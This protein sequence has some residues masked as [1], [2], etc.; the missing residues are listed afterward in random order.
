MK[1]KIEDINL[2]KI[3]QIDKE[4][5]E[6]NKIGEEFKK[7]MNINDELI[8]LDSDSES[9]YVEIEPEEETD[10]TEFSSN[11]EETNVIEF[12]PKEE[13]TVF[14]D[15]YS[16]STDKRAGKL[17]INKNF[18][19]RINKKVIAIVLVGTIVTGV[20]IFS[21]TKS[22]NKKTSSKSVSNNTITTVDQNSSNDEFGNSE[23]D[24][25]IE[26]NT[27]SSKIIAGKNNKLIYDLVKGID[28][29]YYI[30][31]YDINKT[32][33]VDVKNGYLAPDGKVYLSKSEYN[34][35]KNKSNNSKNNFPTST[36]SS[37][38]YYKASDGTL[39]ASKKDRDKYEKSL[40]EQDNYYKASDGTLFENK[41]DR[42]KYE[43][44]L[45]SQSQTK[46]EQTENSTTSKQ[47]YY[48]ADDGTL[49][50]NKEDR[51]KWNESLKKKKNGDITNTSVNSKQYQINE[52]KKIKRELINFNLTYN[53]N[54][55]NSIKSL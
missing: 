45:K 10:V 6:I 37:S 28:G 32:T 33:G 5:D 22:K 42:D 12:S 31:K 9:Q 36:K 7:E 8:S 50:E 4:F 44:I 49:F 48:E 34:K 53:Y 26:V 35:K 15:I 3:S 29:N 41:K 43:E 39:F 21:L 13:E 55:E 52:L 54:E 46:T 14:E 18:F 19:E 16:N 20:A 40:K 38:N 23:L 25:E 1:N 30:R 51:D 47:E 2:T 24:V 17:K 27:Q 11:E